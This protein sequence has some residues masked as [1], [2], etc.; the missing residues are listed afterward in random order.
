[1]TL[2]IAAAIFLGLPVAT[3]LWGMWLTL[4]R[5][6]DDV[7]QSFGDAAHYDTSLSNVQ[8]ANGRDQA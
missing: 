3:I 8:R 2:A 6:N 4:R 5:V 7:E 1:M